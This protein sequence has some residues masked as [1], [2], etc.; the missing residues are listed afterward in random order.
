[1]IFAFLHL[2]DTVL[3]PQHIFDY[4][5]WLTKEG[6]LSGIM[7]EEKARYVSALFEGPRTKERVG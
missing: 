6:H 4:S 5:H 3:L 7:R 2:G 1:M